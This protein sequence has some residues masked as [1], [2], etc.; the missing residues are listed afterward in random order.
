MIKKLFS[1]KSLFSFLIIFFV[2]LFCNYIFLSSYKNKNV[3]SKKQL[4]FA[5]NTEE[6]QEIEDNV[7]KQLGEIDFSKIDSIAGNLDDVQKQAINSYSFSDLVKK[8]IY[9]EGDVFDGNNFFE[10]ILSVILSNLK[11]ILPSFAIITSIG[12]IYSLIKSFSIN[13]KISTSNIAY[14]ACFC[15]VAL[16]VINIVISLSKK[17]SQTI[18]LVEG[19]IEILYPIILSLISALGGTYT[20]ASFHPILASLCSLITRLFVTFLI[21]LFIVIIIFNIVG[22]MSP[23]IKLDKFSKFFFSAFSWIVGIVFTIF[24]G[25]LSISGLLTSN[26]DGIS[27]KTA[28]FALKSYVPILG[29]YLSDGLSLILTS[30]LLIKNA[31]GVAGLIFLLATILSPIFYLIISIL[32]FKLCSALFETLGDEKLSQF[33][34]TISKTLVLLVVCI[35]AISLMFVVSISILIMCSNII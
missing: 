9:G 2:L 34:Y 14:T 12:V 33:L 10:Y 25:F 22:Y 6:A 30:T 7:E 27:I 1:F 29:S 18:M 24:I 5:L 15:A 3:I 35:I 4:F 20:S 11:S 8:L 23:N 13:N 28:K 26:F 32:L 31:V 17:S 21:P 16:I 19:Q